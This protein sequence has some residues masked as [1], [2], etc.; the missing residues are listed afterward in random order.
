M[1]MLSDAEQIFLDEHC[2]RPCGQSDP[3]DARARKDT[4]ITGSAFSVKQSLAKA[5]LHGAGATFPAPIYLLWFQS[6]QREHPEVRLSY[7]AVGSESGVRMLA[8]RGVDFAASTS[9]RRR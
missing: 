1:V 6:F 7:S 4:A 3:G 5:D 9:R 2:R 8:E